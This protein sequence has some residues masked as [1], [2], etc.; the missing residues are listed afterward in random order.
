[1]C[2]TSATGDV[3]AAPSTRAP[4]PRF[5]STNRWLRGRLLATVREAP[6]GAWVEAPD[7]LGEHDRVAVLAALHGLERDGFVELRDGRARLAQDG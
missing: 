4:A 6:S 1:M 5:T 3:A 7:R 2:A